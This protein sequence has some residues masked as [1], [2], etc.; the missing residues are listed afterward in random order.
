LEECYSEE[1]EQRLLVDRSL[2]KP[3]GLLPEP[4]EWA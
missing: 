1:Q 3:A 2:M 4:M